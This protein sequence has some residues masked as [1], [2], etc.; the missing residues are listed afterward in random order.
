MTDSPSALVLA[1][2][3][4]K[5]GVGKSTVAVNLAETLATSGHAVAL[6]DADVGQG[7]CA[8]L[9]NEAPS[10]TAVAVAR[11]AVDVDRILHATDRGVT[12]VSGGASS[13]P[14]GVGPNLYTALDAALE[15]V[16]RT[17]AVVVIDAPAGT[18][19][20]VRWAL[21]RADV[22]LLVLVGEPTAITGAY[23][24]AKM[25]WQTVPDYPLLAVVNAADT[26]EDAAD[27]AERFGEITRQFVGAVPTFVGWLP[28]CAH[29]RTAV[30]TQTPAIRLSQ[31]LRASFGELAQ[32][33][34]ALLP[35]PAA[36]A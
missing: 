17:H 20:P 8:T 19:G 3:S 30:R 5:G 32:A 15:A 6:L 11:G 33:V 29:V 24:L 25:V 12:L 2:V 36:S 35:T 18:D 13:S 14:E 4:G 27:T 26:A 16:S 28:Y 1:V 7:S 21:D 31:S 9:L 22:G 10:A 23:T 34:A